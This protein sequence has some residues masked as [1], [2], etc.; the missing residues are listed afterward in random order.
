[1]LTEEDWGGIGSRASRGHSLPVFA[2]VSSLDPLLHFILS[3]RYQGEVFAT[4]KDRQT[5]KAPQLYLC[6][7]S[8]T[9]QVQ[10]SWPFACVPSC[11][12]VIC[13]A[14]APCLTLGSRDSRTSAVCVCAIVSRFFLVPPPPQHHR[15]RDVCCC[16]SSPAHAT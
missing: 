1:M 16:S 2:C 8:C 11:E 9:L 15:D 4:E 3:V 6:P 10:Y 12:Q 5:L 7:G 13:P 14:S